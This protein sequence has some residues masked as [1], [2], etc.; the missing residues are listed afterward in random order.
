MDYLV[1]SSVHNAVV[2]LSMWNWQSWKQPV[3]NYNDKVAYIRPL[4]HFYV[5]AT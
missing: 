3:D 4:N 5:G 1:Y 2:H